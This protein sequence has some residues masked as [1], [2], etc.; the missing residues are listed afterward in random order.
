[1][2]VMVCHRS[3]RRATRRSSPAP[4][5]GGTSRGA[6]GQGSRRARPSGVAKR[7]SSEHWRSRPRGQSAL[8]GQR[9]VPTPRIRH[10][11]RPASP[12]MSNWRIRRSQTRRGRHAR[13]RSVLVLIGEPSPKPSRRRAGSGPTSLAWP[14]RQRQKARWRLMVRSELVTVPL[15]PGGGRQQQV[16]EARR[17]GAG[18]HLETTSSSQRLRASRTRLPSGRE[19]AGL[20]P[21]TQSARISPV[22]TKQ[23]DGLVPRPAHHG[24]ASPEALY[25]IAPRP[26]QNPMWA[27][28]WVRE[29]PHHA[30]AHGVGLPRHG[31]GSRPGLPMRPHIRWALMM[32]LA[33]S[34]PG[35]TG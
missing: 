22:R 21:S 2:R 25:P 24:R 34:T 9:R 14:P 8:T 27:A 13:R 5:G 35:W 16:G 32:A 29:P 30:P 17:V 15:S 19:T 23:L 18:R 33:L 10:R 4:S 3:R 11:V 20:V 12:E 1:M 28:S 31:E 7:P 6:L 26:R